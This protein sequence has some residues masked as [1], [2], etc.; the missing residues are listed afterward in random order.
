MIGSRPDGWWRDRAGAVRR[1]VRALRALAEAEPA[2]ALTVV[3]DGGPLEGLP[4]GDHGPLRVLYAPRRGPNAADDRIVEIVAADS[5]PSTLRVVSS[6]RALRERVREHGAEVVGTR[7][8]LRR[9]GGAR[10]D[11][12]APRDEGA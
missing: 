9:L 2:L 5:A 10:R 11:V 1:L 8:L 6:D 12:A 3:V 7:T 4:E